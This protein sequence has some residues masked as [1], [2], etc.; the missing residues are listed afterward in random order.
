M[1]TLT[2]SKSSSLRTVLQVGHTHTHTQ[3]RM[4]KHTGSVVNAQLCCSVF[5]VCGRLSEQ[6]WLA[7]QQLWTFLRSHHSHWPADAQPQLQCG[8]NIH[9][10]TRTC[11]VYRCMCWRS[12]VFVQLDTLSLLSLRQLVEVSSSPGF[13][14]SAAAVDNLLLYVPD[15]Q[16]TAFFSPLSTTLQVTHTHLFISILSAS[17]SSDALPFSL[18]GCMWCIWFQSAD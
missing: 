15:A 12:T 1:S 16:F 5:R 11:S 8:T 3:K 4:H 2:S 7:D 17:H 6:L 10:H 13:L 14:S 9:T 18:I